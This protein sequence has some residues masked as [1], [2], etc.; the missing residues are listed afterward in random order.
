MLDSTTWHDFDART[1]FVTAL[2]MAVP[3]EAVDPLPQI[4][5]RSLD[6]TGWSVPPG[7][8]GFIESAGSGIVY[9]AGIELERGLAALERLAAPESESRSQAFDGRRLARVE[10]GYIVLNY[11]KYREKDSTNAERSR[12][13][14]QREKE[15][16]FG[17]VSQRDATALPNAQA[18]AATPSRAVVR[19]EAEAEAEADQEEEDHLVLVAD[20]AI[21]PDPVK[22]VFAAWLSAHVDP[23]QWNRTKLNGVRRA[24]IR[25]RLTEGY[26]PERLVAAINGA[27]RS[28]WNMGDNPEGKEYRELVTLLRDGAQVERLSA[29][30]DAPP[31]IPKANGRGAFKPLPNMDYTPT[32]L[33]E[34]FGPEKSK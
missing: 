29:L 11:M 9:R 24:K 16:R 34:A 3:R 2:L 13:W 19:N 30:V 4:A 27:L 7:W 8:Y 17:G 33:E 31:A 32:T 10:G 21:G 22:L 15:R 25:A 6:P 26:A 12:R 5:V 23:K 14:R 28:K 20:E 1:V 18:N